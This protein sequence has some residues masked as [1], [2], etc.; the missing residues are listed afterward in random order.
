MQYWEAS[1]AVI[2]DQNLDSDPFGDS[3]RRSQRLKVL[4]QQTYRAGR[5]SPTM[6]QT[7][8][9][10]RRTQTM[11]FFLLLIGRSCLRRRVASRKFLLSDNNPAL[12]RVGRDP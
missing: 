11:I 3:S 10:I 12:R 9:P 7:I 4:L 1:K 8:S 6:I 2:S 5:N